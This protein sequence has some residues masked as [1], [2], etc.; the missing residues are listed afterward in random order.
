M[1]KAFAEVH[2]YLIMR[3][4]GDPTGTRYSNVKCAARTVIA[5]GSDVGLF[6]KLMPSGQIW[7]WEDCIKIAPPN[8][9]WSDM[10]TSINSGFLSYQPYQ[11][12]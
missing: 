9:L 1:K 11:A 7:E 5:S 4:N 6:V 12:Q 3:N 10:L 2:P 8:D